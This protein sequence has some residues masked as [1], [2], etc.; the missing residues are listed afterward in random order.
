MVK[1]D[2]KQIVANRSWY[3]HNQL[4]KNKIGFA[5]SRKDLSGEFIKSKYLEGMSLTEIAKILNCAPSTIGNYL[6]RFNVKTRTIQ[7]NDIW[8]Q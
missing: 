2:Y 8:R 7:E 4:T 3:K 6:K 1:R 5:N